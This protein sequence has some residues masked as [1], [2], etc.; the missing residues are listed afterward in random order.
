MRPNFSLILKPA[1]H[2]R[3]LMGCFWPMKLQVTLESI[4]KLM[5]LGNPS[6]LWFK[7]P[8]AGPLLVPMHDLEANS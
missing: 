7:T 2:R 6:P 8:N 3:V 5:R 1:H 4:S